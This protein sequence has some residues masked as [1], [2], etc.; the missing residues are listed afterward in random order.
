MHC[1]IFVARRHCRVQHADSP[2]IE[3]CV[4]SAIR[5]L[6]H[7]T[8]TPNKTLRVERSRDTVKTVRYCW[9]ASTSLLFVAAK[10]DTPLHQTH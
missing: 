9:D 2:L 10:P 1:R 7:E 8:S 5:A 3:R 4:R 6:V